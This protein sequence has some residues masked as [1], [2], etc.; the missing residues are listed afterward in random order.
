MDKENNNNN[1]DEK[2][3]EL[4][5]KNGAAK[6]LQSLIDHFEGDEIQVISLALE[7]LTLIKNADKVEFTNKGESK[8]Q[9]IIIPTKLKKQ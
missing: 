8:P 5:I 9:G 1:Q 6:R 4:T 7:L 3:F 2:T